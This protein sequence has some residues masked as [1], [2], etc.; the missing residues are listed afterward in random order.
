[1]KATPEQR[2]ALAAAIG[3]WDIDAHRDAY[4]DRRI[5]R[6]DTVKDI[7]MRY[8]WDLLWAS[9]FPTRELYDAGLNDGHIDTVLRSIVPAL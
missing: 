3:P 5:P 8:R 6:A 1:M 4:R 2:A 7:D 9:K